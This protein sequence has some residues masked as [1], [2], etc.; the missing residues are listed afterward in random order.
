MSRYYKEKELIVVRARI[1]STIRNSGF[2]VKNLWKVI[3]FGIFFAIWAPTY[4][5]VDQLGR[6][7]SAMETSGLE[8]KELVILT[9]VLYTFFSFLAHFIWQKQDRKRLNRLEQRKRE[10]ENELGLNIKKTQQKKSKES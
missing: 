9:A 4:V 6:S 1:R 10:L 3:G 8:Y 2:F 5:S 7:K